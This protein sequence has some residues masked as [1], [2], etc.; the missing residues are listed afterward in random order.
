[1]RGLCRLEPQG[2]DQTKAK[3]PTHPPA[4]LALTYP[5]PLTGSEISA[6]CRWEGLGMHELDQGV[7]EVLARLSPLSR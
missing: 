7:G 6:L 5:D 1:M 3:A 2:T 4:P